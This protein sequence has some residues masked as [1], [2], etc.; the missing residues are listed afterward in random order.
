[1][2]DEARLFTI[3]K[4]SLKNI[5]ALIWYIG[6]TVLFIKGSSLLIEANGL[7]PLS[8]WPEIAIPTGLIVGIIKGKFLFNKSCEKN[9]ERI[10]QL[11]NPRLWQFFRPGFLFFMVL[12]VIGG[13]T[14]SKL[15]HGNFH[16][17]IAVAILDLSIAT[18]LLWSSQVFWK[19]FIFKGK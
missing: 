14:L 5:S 10:G 12:M 7:Y 8:Y 11:T 15:A 19:A 3:S 4:N 6:S 1:M 17:L 9:L 13:A 18:A 2:L 16:L